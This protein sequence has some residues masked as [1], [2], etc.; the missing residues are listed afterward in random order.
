MQL[1]HPSFEI[2]LAQNANAFLDRFFYRINQREL[3][4]F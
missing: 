3:N 1:V 4:N 2:N